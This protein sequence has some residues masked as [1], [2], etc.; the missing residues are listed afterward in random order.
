MWSDGG[1]TIQKLG[2]SGIPP[3]SISTLI[4]KSLSSSPEETSV[5]SKGSREEDESE[6]SNDVTELS[7]ERASDHQ[8]SSSIP[9]SSGG[10]PVWP[11]FIDAP[12]V[13]VEEPV[14]V[15]EDNSLHDRHGVADSFTGSSR[16]GRFDLALFF[17]WVCHTFLI[18]L[19]V[20]PGS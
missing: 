3:T 13:A 4:Q 6:N 15:D 10:D 11:S 12:P 8:S 5:R 14:V 16:W 2:S 17:K 19:S 1:R 7:K 9:S 18:S 20:L